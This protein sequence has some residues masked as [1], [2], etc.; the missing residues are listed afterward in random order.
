MGKPA[1]LFCKYNILATVAVTDTF[2]PAGNYAGVNVLNPTEDLTHR[3]ANNVGIKDILIDQIDSRTLEFVALLGDF[4][5]GVTM[6][7][8]AST[9]NFT[10]SDVQLL[11]ATVISADLNCAWQALTT[12]GDYRYLKIRLSGISSSLEVAHVCAGELIENPYFEEDW[13]PDNINA[14]GKHLE[15][16]AG[17]YVGS[18][19]EKVMREMVIA[20][21]QLTEVEFAV[22]KN[23]A[24]ECI[25]GMRPFFLV[26]EID[27]DNVYF[28]WI[29]DGVFSA[30]RPNGVRDISEMT[31][32]TRVA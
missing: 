22:Y 20:P 7:V 28:G 9:D 11:A 21:G 27:E 16:S 4:L 26:P 29:S 30:P 3:F 15:S 12:T 18:T 1:L 8:R 17:Y 32:I 31:F 23:W 14:T 6:E 13:L 10:V 5:D 2:S 25:A 19:V 24:Y